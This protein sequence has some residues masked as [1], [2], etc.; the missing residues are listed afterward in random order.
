MTW[1]HGYRKCKPA[2]ADIVLQWSIFSKKEK[3]NWNLGPWGFSPQPPWIQGS[4]SHTHFSRS[5]HGTTFVSY[6]IIKCYMWFI[7]F[8]ISLAQ[9]VRFVHV[10]CSKTEIRRC[11]RVALA[12]ALVPGCRLNSSPGFVVD[13]TGKAQQ[14]AASPHVTSH[15]RCPRSCY[16]VTPLK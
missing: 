11:G 12:L 16:E 2:S 14:S 6:F 3:E 15:T 7:Y 4:L 8:C 5:D 13:F 1:P 9:S 10:L